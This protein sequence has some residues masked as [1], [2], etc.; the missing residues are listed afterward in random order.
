[1]SAYAAARFR[2]V[3]R[4]A[5]RSSSGSRGGDCRC[6]S[7][8]I[9]SSESTALILLPERGSGGEQPTEGAA[10]ANEHGDA[11]GPQ[12]KHG[13]ENRPHLQARVV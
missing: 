1:M 9:A 4:C 12:P 6:S 13:R 3:P 7:E 8:A 5:K 2:R 11:R 10:D